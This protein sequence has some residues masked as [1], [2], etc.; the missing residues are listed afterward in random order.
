MNPKE[1]LKFCLE[2]GLLL[3]EG[4]LKLLSEATDLES[5]KLIIK[6]IQDQTQRKI[7]TKEVFLDKEQASRFFSDLPEENQKR[8]EKLKIKL[9]LRIE[10]S[11]EISTK[12]ITPIKRENL[13]KK[14]KEEAISRV[15]VLSKAVSSGKKYKVEDF[16]KHFRNSFLTIKKILENKPELKNLVSINKASSLG[17]RISIIGMVSSKRI[18]KNE[19]ILFEVEDLTGKIR[20]LVNKNKEDVYKK[21]LDISLDS[22]IGFTG[23][24][25][26]GIFFANQV[27]FPEAALFQRKKSNVEEYAL[28]IGDIQ[29][30]S[31]LFMEENL[32]NFIDYLNEKHPDT[33]EVKKIK[34]LFIAGDVVEGVGVF[35]RQEKGLKI[36][37]LEDQY[38]RLAEILS[39]IPKEITIII[40]PG[41]H[42]GVRLMEPQPTFDEKYAWPLYKLENVVLTGNPVYVNIGARKNFPGFNVLVYHGFSYPYYADTVP[43]FMDMGNVLNMPEKIMAHL[44]KHRHLAPAHNSTQSAPLEEDGLLIK[45][46][47]DIFV[48]GH[49]HKL[50]IFYYNNILLVST[51][52]WEAQDKFQERM[53]NKPDFCKVPMLNLKTGKIKI[54]D[55]ENLKEEEEEKEIQVT[56]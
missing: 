41:N 28:F 45:K 1:I 53:G 2:N 39:K 33:P 16:V 6:K 13:I 4:V 21:A 50:S 49:T 10:I 55:F 46:I 8:L 52:T 12:K 24:G 37:D 56:I 17:Q 7:I 31:N 22:V 42:D 43:S 54:L 25:G 40:S 38:I 51:A 29:C 27:I 44:L 32:L 26:K 30:G 5:A 3:D 35:P 34:Y 14:E 48:S 9:G 36:K 15:K 18:T 47:P 11:K 19:N 20:V 23:S